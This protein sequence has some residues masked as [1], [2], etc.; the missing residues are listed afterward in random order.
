MHVFFIQKVYLLSQIAG[1]HHLYFRQVDIISNPFNQEWQYS[2]L[3]QINL[4][5]TLDLQ[6]DD[7]IFK[8]H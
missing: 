4:F 1:C 6:A 8:Q 3:N 5:H 2:H 7:G